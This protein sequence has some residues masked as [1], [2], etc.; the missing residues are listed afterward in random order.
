MCDICGPPRTR[1][2][3]SSRYRRRSPSKA[4]LM[5]LE[6]LP[7]NGLAIKISQRP[8]CRSPCARGDPVASSPA[9]NGMWGRAHTSGAG[10]VTLHR[11]SAIQIGVGRHEMER[12]IS[13]QLTP[14]QCGTVAPFPSSENFKSSTPDFI[15]ANWVQLRTVR[16]WNVPS[17]G[18]RSKATCG[19]AT[20]HWEPVGV[21]LHRE[22]AIPIGVGRH[23]MERSIF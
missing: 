8:Y 2:S 1:M 22:S 4:L 11:E 16:R 7:E 3:H 10:R 15:D 9:K 20:T 23:R 14:A 12:S 21:T 19:V 17:S 18:P 6:V 13:M 5:C